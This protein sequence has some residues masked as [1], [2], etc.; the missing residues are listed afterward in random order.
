MK[1]NNRDI[2]GELYDQL[3]ASTKHQVMDNLWVMIMVNT[4][5]AVGNQISQIRN[6]VYG[7]IK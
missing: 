1:Y 2:E 7:G 6:H 3:A 4:R 5:K